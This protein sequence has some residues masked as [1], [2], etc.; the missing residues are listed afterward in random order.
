MYL[1][2]FFFRD[3][4]VVLRW[5]FSQAMSKIRQ[6][7]RYLNRRAQLLA[8]LDLKRAS[9]SALAP[10]LKRRTPKASKSKRSGGPA[11]SP[12]E[13]LALQEQLDAEVRS[14]NSHCRGSRMWGSGYWVSCTFCSM[15]TLV[16]RD[17]GALSALMDLQEQQLIRVE[18]GGPLQLFCAP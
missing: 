2:Y 17:A 7:P 16:L 6:T 4:S 9:S 15:E 10:R 1:I 11:L 18:G 5:L 14:C 8:E 3:R 12:E 13:E